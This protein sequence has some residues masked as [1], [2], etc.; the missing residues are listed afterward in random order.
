MR[1]FASLSRRFLAVAAVWVAAVAGAGAARADD[2]AP[3]VSG[4]AAGSAVARLTA[5]EG[6]MLARR[7]PDWERKPAAERER[8]AT[9]VLRL[10][11]LS[12]EQRARFFE[13]LRRA[14]EAGPAVLADLPDRLA[15]YG[16]LRPEERKSA[17]EGG[18]VE[19]AILGAVRA[20]VA[21]ATLAAMDGL[22]P[23]ERMLLGAGIL[24]DFRR[25]AAQA[26]GLLAMRERMRAAAG[27][28]PPPTPD[29]RPEARLAHERALQGA[30]ADAFPAARDAVALDLDA[31]AGKGR[32][33]LYE[34]A[35]QHA[36]APPRGPTLWNAV[37]ALERGRDLLPEDARGKVD[38]AQ[39]ALLQV[40]KVPD[41]DLV[42]LRA[43]KTPAERVVLLWDLQQRLRPRSPG[44]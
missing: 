2:P 10:R 5:E 12:A 8:I 39:V 35:K 34:Y 13:R 37:N 44:K 14:Q 18:R 26:G 36:P 42:R 23:P 29:P 43:A 24:A 9:N 16:K 41:E 38:E 25:R 1:A 22:A 11:D 17:K 30:L 20:K 31:A 27:A 21:P 28:V 40:L 32:E 7:F 3:P 19:R 15:A 4:P 33:G 6:A